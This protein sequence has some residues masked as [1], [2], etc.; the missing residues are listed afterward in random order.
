MLSH[1]MWE[2]SVEFG[3]VL[4]LGKGFELGFSGTP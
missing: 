4:F 2:L 3:V 1:G